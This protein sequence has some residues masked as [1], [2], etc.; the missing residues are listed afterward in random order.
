MGGLPG[1]IAIGGLSW[2][3]G[4]CEGQ[5][6]FVD[7]LGNGRP[8]KLVRTGTVFEAFIPCLYTDCQMCDI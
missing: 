5:P 4:Y 8:T 7:N 2:T 3:D 1:Y 6:D